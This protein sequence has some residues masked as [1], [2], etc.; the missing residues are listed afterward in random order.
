MITPAADLTLDCRQLMYPG[1]VLKAER[2]LATMSAGQVLDVLATDENVKPDP[3]TWAR[4]LACEL[5]GVRDEDG[6][7]AFSVRK[8]PSPAGARHEGKEENRFFLVVLRSGL[9]APGQ[10]RAGLMYASIAAAMRA[11]YQAHGTL[12]CY[13]VVMPS[14]G[15]RRAELE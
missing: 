2:Q 15:R 7:F 14:G 11:F 3:G 4:R 13:N 6:H 12:P 9:N 10:V 1:P 8:A 5:L